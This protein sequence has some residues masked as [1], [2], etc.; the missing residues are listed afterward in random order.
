MFVHL[1]INTRIESYYTFITEHYPLNLP[2]FIARRLAFSKEPSFTKVIVKIAIVAIAI[3]LAVMII[4][5]AMITGFK[6]EITNKIFGFWG[7]IHITDS[8]KSTSFD[9]RPIDRNDEYYYTL[10]DIDTIEHQQP[11]SMMGVELEERYTTELTSGGV[12]YAQVYAMIPGIITAKARNFEGIMFKGVG[13]DYHWEIMEDFLIDGRVI[14]TQSDSVSNDIMIS[15][16]TSKRLRMNV[17]DPMI[18]SFFKDRKQIR[19]RMEVVG[20]YNTGL[21]EYDRKFAITDIRKLQDVMDWQPNQVGG[22]EVFVDHLE[23]ID[24]ISDYIHLEHLPPSIYSRTIREKYSGIFDWLELQDIN[25]LVILGLMIIVAIINMITALLILIL[26]R[27]KMIGTLKALGANDWDVRKIFLYYAAYIV[28]W[29]ML[30]GNLL[31]LTICWIQKKYGIIELD[32]ANYYISVAPIDVQL[33]NL[34]L[35]NIACFFITIIFLVL[36]T[37]LVTRISPMKALRFG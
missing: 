12:K 34:L 21:D 30:F 20:I 22:I 13:D 11:A 32:E 15:K 29:G 28:L 35:I 5:T 31:G 9:Q 2:Y 37:Y 24:L 10:Q 3:S 36:P 33:S 18:V 1:D 27:T 23:D 6:K 14:D 16:V 26:D 25:E 17:G 7:H 4:T 19:K 8:I